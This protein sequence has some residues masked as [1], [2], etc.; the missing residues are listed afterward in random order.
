LTL[1]LFYQE[2]EYDRWL[3]FDRHIRRPLRRLLRGRPV[4]GGHTLVFLN[5]VKGLE[6]LG[7]SYRINDFRYIRRHAD[8]LA[9]I[10]GK[11]H[12][13]LEREWRNPVLFGAAVFSHPSDCPALFEQRP[14]RRVL[15]PGPWMQRMFEPYY[16]DRV[17]AWPVG[18][19]TDEWSPMGRE[20]SVDILLY[21]KV[22][23]E[24]ERFEDDL[25]EPLRTSLRRRGCSI[26]EIR[27]GHYKPQDLRDALSRCRA[28]VFLCE[29][30]TQGLAYQQMLSS[31]VPIFAWDRGGV[32]RD[33]AYYPRFVEGPVTSV[34]Y[35]DERCGHTFID[36]AQFEVRF[37]EFW[38]AARAGAFQ[39]R[40]YVLDNLTL[41][42]CARAYLD[43]VERIAD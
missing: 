36:A 27:Y 29:H 26:S 11:P 22:R 24:H 30:E 31:G 8:D 1:N 21:D 18:I 35:W 14:V 9:C 32:W 42:R 37:D 2:P 38:A 16:G 15:V 6:C 33:P 34:P 19:D 12:V 25:I 4:P 40:S 13:L 23:W 17:T 43:I 41:E 39:P 3:P 20:K 5:L 28:A 10:V 7:V